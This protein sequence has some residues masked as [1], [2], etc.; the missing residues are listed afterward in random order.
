MKGLIMMNKEMK[1]DRKSIKIGYE[2]WKLLREDFKRTDR[3]MIDILNEIVNE[4]Y[5]NK[6]TNN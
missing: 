6:D 2:E 1:T 3:P 4:Y 5:K